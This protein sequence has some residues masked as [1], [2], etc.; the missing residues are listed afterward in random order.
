MLTLTTLSLG[1]VFAI[2]QADVG[3]EG[4]FKDSVDSV[5]ECF[6]VSGLPLALNGSFIISSGGKFSMGGKKFVGAFDV[7]GK[8]HSFDF[9]AEGRNPAV[10]LTSLG[11][12][13]AWRE[14]ARIELRADIV[15]ESAKYESWLR[16]TYATPQI[17]SRI[18]PAPALLYNYM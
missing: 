9:G 15:R 11:K 5:N 1:V 18:A 13:C 12:A 4:L 3:F 10:A 14:I 17:V 7:F 6:A 2:N 8:L 16:V